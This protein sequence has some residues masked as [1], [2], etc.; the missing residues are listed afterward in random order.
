M[1]RALDVL[2]MKEEDVLKS[3]AAG[4]H[5]DGTHVDFQAEHCI[6]ERKSYDTSAVNLKRSW[7]KF[8][9]AARAIDVSENPADVR[10]LSSQNADQRAI[11]KFAAA[12]GAT[13]AAGHFG[14]RTFTHQILEP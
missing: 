9:L 4:A 5:L 13:P 2:R 12:T 14:P 6:C 1:P 8:P 7:E 11:L 10:V 3:L